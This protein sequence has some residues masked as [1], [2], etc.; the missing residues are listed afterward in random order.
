MTTSKLLLTALAASFVLPLVQAQDAASLAYRD[1]V[2][3]LPAGWTGPVF[4][5]S[6]DYPT[7]AASACDVKEC[8]WLATSPSMF[9]QAPGSSVPVWDAQWSAYIKKIF[10]YIKEGQD[11]DGIRYSEKL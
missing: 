10:D 8:P 5:L 4:H 7:Q 2:E 1:A 6:H 9:N 3:S 11:P